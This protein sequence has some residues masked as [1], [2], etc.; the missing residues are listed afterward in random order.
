MGALIEHR[1]RDLR[2]AQ[3]AIEG[4]DRW[5]GALMATLAHDVRSPLSTVVGVLEVLEDDPATPQRH[6]PLLAGAQRQAARILR[7]AIGMLEVERAEH[8]MLRLDLSEVSLHQLATEVAALTD[9]L[10]VRVDIDPALYARVDPARVEQVLYNLT[11]NALRHGTAPVVLSAAVDGARRRAA[12][13]RPRRGG[14]GRRGAPFSTGSARPTTPRRPSASGC[15]SCGC[16]P[17]PTAGTSA[18]RT[19][20]PAQLGARS[21][22]G[23]GGGGSRGA[24]GGGGGAGAGGRGP[25]GGRDGGEGGGGGPRPVSAAGAGRP[26]R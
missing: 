15:G 13:A 11:T 23:R 21:R 22:G 2:A 9:P 24:G 12:R 4:K 19:P 1:V 18:T 5:R 25:G 14:P 3:E 16:S 10:A 7:L 6:R 8:G 26:G 17:R 20:G